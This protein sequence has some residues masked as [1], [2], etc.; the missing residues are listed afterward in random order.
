VFHNYLRDEKLEKMDPKNQANQV[1]QVGATRRQ[2]TRLRHKQGAPNKITAE[3]K[4]LTHEY[5][6]MAIKELARLAVKG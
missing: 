3:I 6:P 1:N 5:G 2:T 4:E